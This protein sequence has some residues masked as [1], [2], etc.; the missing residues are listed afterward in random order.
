M[1]SRGKKV[2]DV[3]IIAAKKK[4]IG[5]LTDIIQ[6]FNFRVESFKAGQLVLC[7]LVKYYGLEKEGTLLIDLGAESTHI[8]MFYK[9]MYWGRTLHLGTCK[10]T[11]LIADE[12]SID[13][14]EAEKMKKTQAQDG[15]FLITQ[16]KERGIAGGTSHV[17][18]RAIEDVLYEMVNEVSRTISYYLSVVR[19]AVFNRIILTGGGANIKH[20]NAFFEKNLGLK[21][22]IGNFIPRVTLSSYLEGRFNYDKNFY[23]I[24]IGIACSYR[25]SKA[26]EA[27]LLSQ[28]LR[29]E[30]V[31][32]VR[33]ERFHFF[34]LIMIF[35][36]FTLAVNFTYEYSVKQK[37]ERLIKTQLAHIEKNEKQLK[38]IEND[39]TIDKNRLMLLAQRNDEREFLLRL[40]QEIEALLLD[41][42]WFDAV[43]Y[44]KD[45]Q[46][47]I[48]SG[49]TTETLADINNFQSALRGLNFVHDVTFEAAHIEEETLDGKPMRIFTVNVRFTPLEN[50]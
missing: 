21:S 19:G 22:Q 8:L 17:V 47:L 30:R 20:I 4:L 5:A 38:R 40:L 9:E 27:P 50:D 44:K 10:M 24:T 31:V 48:I 42:V 39:I 2:V 41:N 33:K 32:E 28:S 13:I 18:I 15:T 6:S 29:E 26:L 1:P 7:N 49:R 16:K 3:V 43:E 35:I 11:K 46:T 37:K 45:N 23:G 12:L 25:F 34:F 36:L 14:K